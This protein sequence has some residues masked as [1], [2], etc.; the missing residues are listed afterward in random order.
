MYSY[1][2][3]T[4]DIIHYHLNGGDGFFCVV[5]GGFLVRDWIL[6]KAM[7]LMMWENAIASRKV[8]VVVVR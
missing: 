6:G 5:L 4:T 7:D 2:G 3:E 8:S 1:S